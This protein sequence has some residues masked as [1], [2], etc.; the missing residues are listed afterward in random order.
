MVRN[1]L[2]S[3]SEENN[4]IRNSQHDFRNERSCLTNLRDFYN[5]IYEETEVGD[6]QKAFDK[7]PWKRSLTNESN[8][9]SYKIFK[10]LQDWLSERK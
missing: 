3:F 1:K 10:W 9:I 8:N 7:V 2:L 4:L 6:V 5:D